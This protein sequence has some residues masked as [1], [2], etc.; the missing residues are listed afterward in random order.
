MMC[1]C[2]CGGVCVVSE[3]FVS[4]FLSKSDVPRRSRDGE[5]GKEKR[6]AQ[7]RS[8]IHVVCCVCRERDHTTKQRNNPHRLT[9]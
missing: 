6:P 1:V 2:V 7:F 5:G 4:T 9:D 3:Y 8:S